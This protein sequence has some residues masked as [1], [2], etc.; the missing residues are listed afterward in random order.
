MKSTINILDYEPLIYKIINKF[1][2]DF[3]QDLY[4]ECYIKLNDIIDRYDSTKGTFQT[5]AYKHLYFLC[6]HFVQDNTLNHQSLKEVVYNEEGE[7]KTHLDL[8]EDDFN[9]EQSIINTDYL[10]NYNKNLTHI[11]EFIQNKYYQEGVSVRKIIEVY[12]PYHQIK[13]V[14]TIKK[15]LTK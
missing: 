12:Q 10:N 7:E 14:K 15:I 1:D 11:E 5:Y 3:E 9:L 8:L 4:N 2:K 6:L 13:S